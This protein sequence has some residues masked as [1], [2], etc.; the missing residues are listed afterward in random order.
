[1]GVGGGSREGEGRRGNLRDWNRH[2]H[3]T[4]YIIINENLLYSTGNSTQYYVMPCMG[5]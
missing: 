2:I 5:K 3:T 1:M 4:I